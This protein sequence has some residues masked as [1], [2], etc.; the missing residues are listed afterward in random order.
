MDIPID[1]L[2]RF[3]ARIDFIVDESMEPLF[4][5]IRKALC[6]EWRD[7]FRRASQVYGVRVAIELPESTLEA[8][9]Q[10]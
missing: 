3:K 8:E 10:I 9:I 4:Y 2:E 5:E 1:V 6:A 7:G